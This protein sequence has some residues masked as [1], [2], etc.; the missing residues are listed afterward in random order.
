M[1]AKTWFFVPAG[2]LIQ[3][4]GGPAVVHALLASAAGGLG[5]LR[6]YDGRRADD[7]LALAVNLAEQEAPFYVRFPAGSP[8][9][10][11]RGLLVEA[12]GCDVAVLI[13]A[14]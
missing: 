9:P 12:G 6:L 2:S 10:L 11:A 7:P 1:S 3:V 4:A 13:S 14:A 5:C 8:L